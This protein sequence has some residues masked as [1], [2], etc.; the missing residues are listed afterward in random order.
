M[1]CKNRLNWPLKGPAIIDSQKTKQEPMFAKQLLAMLALTSTSMGT[2]L[3]A[4][5]PAQVLAQEDAAL[6][7]NQRAGLRPP[8]GKIWRGATITTEAEGQA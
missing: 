2:R 6:P 8:A 3:A 7:P 4:E 1:R 5:A